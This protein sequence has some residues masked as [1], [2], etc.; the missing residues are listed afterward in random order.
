[1]Q[2]VGCYAKKTQMTKT[3]T[4]PMADTSKNNIDKKLDF[5]SGYQMLGG[6]VGLAFI[7]YI[8]LKLDEINLDYILLL[9]P[10]ILIYVFS[11]MSGL[12]LYQRKTYGLRL[13]LINQILQI[14]GFSLGGFGFEYVAGLSFDFFIKYTDGIDITSNVGL[15]NWHILINNDTGI[16]EISINI[17]AIFLAFFILR[18]RK[19]YNLES[20]LNEIS[21]IGT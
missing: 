14:V 10:G 15:S 13:S 2:N 9:G 4:T 16:Q 8:F 18:L 20:P 12:F 3:L 5:F 19:E 7:A 1:M 17:V 6:L 21:D 11:F